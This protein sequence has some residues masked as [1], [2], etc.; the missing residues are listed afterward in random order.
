MQQKLSQKADAPAL[1]FRRTPMRNLPRYCGAGAGS[2][3]FACDFLGGAVVSTSDRNGQ[4]C[5]RT[6]MALNL[7]NVP[8]GLESN[9]ILWAN[10]RLM[11]WLN[12]V[13]LYQRRPW[14]CISTV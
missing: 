7:S 14:S 2:G 9:A 11:Q 1:R 4:R 5:P 6:R 8:P 13:A 3:F 12:R 10:G